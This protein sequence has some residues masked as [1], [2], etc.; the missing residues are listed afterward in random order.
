[1]ESTNRR[2]EEQVFKFET[3]GF[4]LLIVKQYDNKNMILIF[5]ARSKYHFHR[6]KVETET[7]SIYNSFSKINLA[8]EEKSVINL[9]N[10]KAPSE[11]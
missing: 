5:T 8:F 6:K 9:I 7:S 11:I 2:K 1:M 3:I 10:E 4:E